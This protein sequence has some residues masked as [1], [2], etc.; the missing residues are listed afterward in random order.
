MAGAVGGGGVGD[1]ALNY[2]YQRFD[3]VAMAITVITL[4]IIVQVCSLLGTT[5]LKRLA[6][7]E[8]KE[9]KIVLFP[10][11]HKAKTKN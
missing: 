5:W 6:T 11:K 7:I 2:G 9:Y 10:L 1:L 4:V 3:N 8:T